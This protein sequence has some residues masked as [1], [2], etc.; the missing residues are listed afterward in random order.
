MQGYTCNISQS[1]LLCNLGKKVPEN[2]ILWLQLDF[3]ALSM[4]KEIEKNCAIIQHG[5]LGKVVWT[6]YKKE[7]KNYD[8]GVCFFTREEKTS[9]NWFTRQ[10]TQNENQA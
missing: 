5:I 10:T 8:V 9:D 3:G 1:G 6:S 2:S 7:D 4:C